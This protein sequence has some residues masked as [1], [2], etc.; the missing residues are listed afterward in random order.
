MKDVVYDI[1]SS[2]TDPFKNVSKEVITDRNDLVLQQF[3]EKQERK[4][5][6]IADDVD[7]LVNSR[8]N[9]SPKFS[10]AKGGF[11]TPGMLIAPTFSA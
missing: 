1:P 11:T 7:I 6:G 8:L 4:K 10:S 5:Q 9:V 3:L 2:N